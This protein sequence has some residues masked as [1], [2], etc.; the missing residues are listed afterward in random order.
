MHESDDED[1][2]SKTQ[3]K[4]ECDALQKLGEDLT[5]LKD[6][7]LDT[8]D[9]PDELYIAIKDAR[10][11]RQHGAL[12]RHRQ[13]IGRLMRGIDAEPVAQQLQKIRHKDDVHTALFKRLENWRDQIIEEGDKAINEIIKELPNADRQYLRQLSR[14]AQKEQ[15]QKK[16]PVAFRQI[17]KY[18]RDLSEN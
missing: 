12:K 7:E 18:L 1:F 8:F 15:K 11:I 6:S 2:I 9:L 16:P 13:Y 3:R 10:K 5:T 17:F 4:T 14:N